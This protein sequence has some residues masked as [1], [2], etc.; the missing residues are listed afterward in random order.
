[1]RE[2]SAAFQMKREG[3]TPYTG[4]FYALKDRNFTNRNQSIREGNNC[5]TMVFRVDIK[6]SSGMENCHIVLASNPKT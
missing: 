5:R 6:T 4:G 2:N 1:M 3:G